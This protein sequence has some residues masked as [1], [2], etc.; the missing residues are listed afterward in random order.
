MGR[1]THYARAC[2]GGEEA[3]LVLEGVE[4]RGVELLGAGDALHQLLDVLVRK[5][6]LY[7]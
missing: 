1:E 4:E 5:H 3:D 7:T 2:D 6:V